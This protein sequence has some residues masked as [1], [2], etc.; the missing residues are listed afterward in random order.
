MYTRVGST[1]SYSRIISASDTTTAVAL[2][3][4]SVRVGR[5]DHFQMATSTSGQSR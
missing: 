4:T 2:T 3:I 5:F 1:P